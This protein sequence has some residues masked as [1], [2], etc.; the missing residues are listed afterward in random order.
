MT[1]F[2]TISSFLDDFVFL[3]YPQTCCCCDTALTKAETY[4]CLQ[5]DLDL[6]IVS[7]QDAIENKF[8]GKINFHK[9]FALYQ[10][11]KQNY[12]HKI[13]EEIKYKDNQE[14]A[15]FM[16]Q[17]IGNKLLLDDFENYDGIVPVP[18]HTS[19]QSQRGYNQS[20][21]LAEGIADTT[22]LKVIN[23]VLFRTTA[24]NTQTRKQRFARWLNVETVFEA[25]E[26]SEGKKL[27]LID[28]VLTTGATLVACAEALLKSKTAEV[29]FVSLASAV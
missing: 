11:T 15:F 21:L 25:N 18:L 26:N 16:G 14:L 9:S 20:L 1:S 2:S 17:R 6:P 7:N 23:D 19:R 13:L 22:N 8:M 27:I 12:L 5:C 4:I 28:D 3:I 29:S 24:T 10:Y